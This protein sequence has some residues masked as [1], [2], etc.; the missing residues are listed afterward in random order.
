L[1]PV[2]ASG[3][4]MDGL[5]AATLNA[6]I[7]ADPRS[8]PGDGQ[9]LVLGQ[10]DEPGRLDAHRPVALEALQLLVDALARGAEQLGDVFLR[11]L[12]ADRISS[13]C[14]TP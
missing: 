2:L 5:E 8:A 4:V 1:V 7:R 3:W 13:P 11:Q 9:Q 14:S 12:Q 10:D 6:A